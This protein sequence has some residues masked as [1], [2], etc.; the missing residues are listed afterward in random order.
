MEI[1]NLYDELCSLENLTLAWRKARKG[2]TLHDDIIEFKK[3]LE[4]NLLNLHYELK[5]KTYKPKPLSLFVLR[6]PKTRLIAKSD[7]RDRIIHHALI[8]VIESIFEKQFIYDSCANQKGKGTL[9][10]LKRFDNYTRKVSNNHTSPA[11]CLK[12]DIKHYFQEI[13]LHILLEILKRKIKDKDVIWLIKQIL[14]NHG[15]CIGGGRSTFC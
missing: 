6:D 7:F 4:K 8:N 3:N 5:N 1:N 15:E 10:A 9:L 2:K 11:F 14:Y 13:N 12:A